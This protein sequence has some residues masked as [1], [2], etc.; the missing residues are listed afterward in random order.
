M[1]NIALSILLLVLITNIYSQNQEKR[2]A[3]VI[4][5]SSYEGGTALKNPE[6]DAK[7][8]A[9][10]LQELG[11]FVIK[12]VNATEK[13]MEDA[14]EKF[15]LK[16]PDYD[17]ALFYYAGHGMQV[18]GINY[19]IPVDAELKNRIAIRHE[20]ISVNDIV[21][22]FEYYQDNVNIVILDA[23]RNNPYRSW[24][25]GGVR[26]FI[27]M[28]P[29]SGTIVA[30]AT[31]EGATATD[32]EYE[33]GL[34]TEQL[35]KQLK[36]EQRIVDV[37]NNTRIAVER[38]SNGQQSP[39][40]WTK[41]KGPFYFKKTSEII[42][43]IPIQTEG[44]KDDVINGF[45]QGDVSENYGT[46]IIDSEIAGKFY[47]DGE[48]KGYI[49]KNSKGNKL[50]KTSI[51]KH[52]VIIIGDQTWTKTIVVLRDTVT[53]IKVTDPRKVNTKIKEILPKV[54]TD[55]RD[56]KKYKIQK[57][58]DQVWMTENLAYDAGS[59]SW[60]YEGNESNIKEFGYLYNWRTAKIACPV[61]W[62]L[63]TMR[64][65]EVLLENV[66]ENPVKRYNALMPNG[67]SEFSAQLGG[68]RYLDKRYKYLNKFGNYWSSTSLDKKRAWLLYMYSYRK[69]AY[70]H[71]YE[72]TWGFSVRCIKK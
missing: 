34:Y 14:I 37:F 63:P 42:T 3:L 45:I 8:M 70:M 66:G 1:K 25:R 29:A 4:G 68:W 16:L 19:L 64:D 20:T 40:E 17:V 61:G 54:I 5:N 41:L 67:G 24:S 72:K 31:S 65:Y 47:F 26:G 38:V 58:A 62:R 53:N 48:Y 44:E 69:K 23:C 57:I 71:K 9:E 56:E 52:V 46:V 15:S 12:R 22:E 51:G 33:N 49:K 21:S 30:F 18:D 60:A 7:L 43:P 32:G 59:G 39:Q 28:K 6:N 11:F 27:A 50:M 36:I 13:E 55:I 35:V 10:T 2:I